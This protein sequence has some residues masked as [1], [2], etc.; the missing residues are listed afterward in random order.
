MMS[1]EKMEASFKYTY[2]AK[3]QEEIRKIRQKYQVEDENGMEQLRKLDSI[4]TNRA[5]CIALIL[6]IV[7]TLIMGL[8]ISLILTNLGSF[9]GLQKMIN[10]VIGIVSGV[11]GIALATSAYPVYRHII[12]KE[13]AKIA[14]EILKLTEMLMK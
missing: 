4:A 5:T 2:S 6:G 10:M 9:F 7:G 1:M 11:I 8:G 12:K 3:E 13:R 14:P